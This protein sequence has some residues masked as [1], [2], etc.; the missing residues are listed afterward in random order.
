MSNVCSF[1]YLLRCV[2]SQLFYNTATSTNALLRLFRHGLCSHFFHLFDWNTAEFDDYSKNLLERI[3]LVPTI[4]SICVTI[5]TGKA[6]ENAKGT[7][8][9]NLFDPVTGEVSVAGVSVPMSVWSNAIPNMQV[10]FQS[11]FEP[12]FLR[13]DLLKSVLNPDNQLVW[14]GDQSTVLVTDTN[15]SEY[16]RRIILLSYYF[17]MHNVTQ[18]CFKFTYLYC[19]SASD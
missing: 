7:A 2:S 15:G 19:N 18:Q 6:I 16:S 14:M 12:L 10:R 17:C 1:Y 11:I 8:V 13:Q 3:K 9:E 5:K 4:D